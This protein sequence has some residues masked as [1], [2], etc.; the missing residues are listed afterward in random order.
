[1][2]NYLKDMFVEVREQKEASS[3]DDVIDKDFIEET[4]KI[5]IKT[6]INMIEEAVEESTETIAEEVPNIGAAS[7]DEAIEMI[8]KMIPNIEVSEIGRSD[9][10]TPDEADEKEIK[11]PQRQLLEGYLSNIQGSDFADKIRSVSQFYTNGISMVE[12]QAGDERTKRISQAISYLVFYKTLTKVITNFNASSAGFSFESF[13]AAL[14][15]GY[16][17]PANT[18]TIADY[19]DRSTGEEIPVSLKLYKEGNL[20]VGGSYTDLVR[21][22]V[23]PK[24]PGAIGGAMRYVVCT[25]T[26]SGDDLEQ[27][28]RIDFY[29][30]DISLKNVMNI[31]ANSKQRSQECIR[32]PKQIASALKSGRVDGV[33]M[34]DTLPG[35]ANL[36]SDEDL[37]K[38][39]IKYLDEAFKMKGISL[40]QMQ[41]NDILQGIDYGKKDEMFNDWVQQIGEDKVN[42]G[43]VRGRSTLNKDKLRQ[44]LQ[45]FDWMPV[46]NDQGQVVSDYYLAGYIIA[47]NNAVIGDQKKQKLADKRNQEIRRMVAEGEFLS[48][49]ESAKAYTDMGDRQKR[50]ALENSWGYLTR[51]HFSLNQK[52]ALSQGP[53]TS[54]LNLGS[55]NV[56]REEVA[57]VVG[58]IRDILNEEVMEIFQSLKILSDSLNTFFAGGLSDDSLASASIDNAN[59]ISS[60]EILKSDK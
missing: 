7:D 31:I 50:V 28:G 27:E 12:A 14:V 46:Q 59:N 33:S 55:I 16:Q 10:R 8:L 13:L 5:D 11:G 6:L 25:K 15:N 38:I 22:L 51:G 26:L 39:F 30:F 24:W 52:Q 40:S 56:G 54:T 1:M 35:E 43:V 19:V 57:K 45:N 18:G 37:E 49:E 21:D 47:A 32:I 53:P 58:N 42:K 60:K 17:I 20:E 48:P 36:P 34:A 41:T 29:Q 4:R 44:L 9:V 2:G 23:D 3:L